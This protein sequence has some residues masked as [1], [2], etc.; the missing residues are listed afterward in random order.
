MHRRN[1]KQG[2]LTAVNAREDVQIN[3]KYC[4]KQCTLSHKLR[5]ESFVHPNPR[6]GCQHVSQYTSRGVGITQCVQLTAPHI[7]D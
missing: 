3:T 5:S 6:K 2:E 7:V 4:T 1:V